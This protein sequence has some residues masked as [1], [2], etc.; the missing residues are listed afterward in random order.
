[1]PPALAVAPEIVAVSWTGVPTSA[2]EVESVVVIAGP[3]LV[4]ASGSHGEVAP[5]SLPSPL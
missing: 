3:L 5:M 4:T 1:M 2:T